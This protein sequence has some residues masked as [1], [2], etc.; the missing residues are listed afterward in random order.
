LVRNAPVAMIVSDR[1]TQQIELAN[2][3]FVKLFGYSL[4]DIPGVQHW[5]P[6]TYPD[7]S[8]RERVKA[9]WTAF[10]TIPNASNAWKRVYAARMESFSILSSTCRSWVIRFWSASWI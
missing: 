6:I 8:Y 1:K 2:D 4:E 9:E 10:L 5:W 7:E 3:R